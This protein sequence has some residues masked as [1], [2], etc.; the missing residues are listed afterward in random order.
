MF[1]F[2][3]TCQQILSSLRGQS[4]L[5]VIFSCINGL[6]IYFCSVSEDTQDAVRDPGIREQWGSRT[7]RSSPNMIVYRKVR[8]LVERWGHCCVSVTCG[9]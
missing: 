1:H 4:F 5:Y 7:Q 6:F 2:H 8:H 9:G 3:A